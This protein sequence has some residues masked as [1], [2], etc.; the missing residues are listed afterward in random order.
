M[1]VTIRQASALS[2]RK[3]HMATSFAYLALIGLKIQIEMAQHMVA[4]VARLIAQRLEFRQCCRC[5][6]APLDHGVAHI[7]QRLLQLAIVQGSMRIVLE[8]R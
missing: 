5:C 7:A 8:L 3:M 6:G 4:D 1:S 2:R